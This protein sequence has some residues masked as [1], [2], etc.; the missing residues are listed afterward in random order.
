MAQTQTARYR[1]TLTMRPLH[2]LHMMCL[3][4]VNAFYLLIEVIL[5]RETSSVGY[6][7]SKSTLPPG[8][9]FNGFQLVGSRKLRLFIGAMK[10]FKEICV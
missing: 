7:T 3:V 10:I 2:I 4:N 6:G 9:I 5:K 1:V 8:T